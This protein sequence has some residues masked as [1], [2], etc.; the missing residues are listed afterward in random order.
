MADQSRV[1][2]HD[3]AAEQAVLGAILLDNSALDR[4][5]LK[6][7]DFYDR[8]H[9]LIFRTMQRMTAQGK[10]LDHVTVYDALKAESG[11]PLGSYLSELAETTPSAANIGDYARH[12]AGQCGKHGR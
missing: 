7:E 8:R 12:C 10:A 6:P 9:I 1:P 3:P 5:P 2:S 11:Q 4:V